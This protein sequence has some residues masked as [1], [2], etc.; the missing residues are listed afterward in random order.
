MYKWTKADLF[1][2]IEYNKETLDRFVS[3]F[4]KYFDTEVEPIETA[5]DIKEYDINTIII[6]ETFPNLNPSKKILNKN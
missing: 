2:G 4:K 3:F 6:E 1:S 5:K